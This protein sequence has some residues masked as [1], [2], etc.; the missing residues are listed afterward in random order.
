MPV[1][2]THTALSSRHL[3]VH[4]KES[5]HVRSLSPPNPDPAEPAV[6]LALTIGA[7]LSA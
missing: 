5:R 7:A 3:F 4:A 6:I 2:R 1:R